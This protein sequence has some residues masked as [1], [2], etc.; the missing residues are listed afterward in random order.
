MNYY[1]KYYSDF[2]DRD[3]NIM[4]I[5][6]YTSS[7]Y[8][9]EEVMVSTE[10]M[11][12]DYTAESLFDSLKPSKASVNILVRELSTILFTGTLNGTC[13]KLF[14]NSSLFWM[15]YVQP[16]VYTQ[17]YKDYYDVLTLQCIDTIA[18][19]QNVTYKYSPNSDEGTIS[20]FFDVITHC[21][22]Y[23]DPNHFIST[24]YVDNSIKAGSLFSVLDNVYIQERNF[25]DESN[26]A[27]NC[28]E[29][30]GSILKYLGLTMIQYRD[31]YYIIEQGS[32]LFQA[33]YSLNKY[34]YS[35]GWSKTGT[36][37]LALTSLSS[38]QIGIGHG[39]GEVGLDG[40]FNKVTVIANNNPL[41]QILPDFDDTND[42]VNMNSNPNMKYEENYSYNDT[43]YNLISGFFK[44]K[45]N[46]N[47]T[48][49]QVLESGTYYGSYATPVSEVTGS[50]RD[51]IVGGC[52]WQ[53]TDSYDINEGV[54]SSL[55]W[56]TWLTMTYSPLIMGLSLPNIQLNK[57]K[58]M[59]LDGGYLIV[60]LKYKFSTD[61]RAHSVIHSKNAHDEYI[62]D[63]MWTSNVDKIGA[64]SWTRQGTTK[65]RAILNVGG[66]CYTGR[67]QTNNGWELISDV[68]A[69]QQRYNSL[70]GGMGW[71]WSGNTRHWYR[72]LNSYGDWE[73][74]TESQ[75]NAFSGTKEDGDCE[76]ANAQ[77]MVRSDNNERVYITPEFYEE[78]TN[79]YGFYLCH[80]NKTNEK[81]Y[82]TEYSLTN[83][84]SYNMN[85]T[86]S[87]DG[88][89][90]KCPDFALY[91]QLEFQVFAP[92]TLGSNPNPR[93]DIAGTT[94]KAVHFS[95]LTIK[96]SKSRAYKSIYDNS[97]VDP[98]TKYTNVIY[99]GF[100]KELDDVE[101]K[102]NTKN[103]YATSYSYAIGKDGNNYY[104]I[105]DFNFGNGI[106]KPEEYLVNKYVNHYQTPKYQYGNVLKNRNATSGR[107]NG[108]LTPFFPLRET[109]GGV[110]R[111]M[112]VRDI[113]YD[114]SANTAKIIAQEI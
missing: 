69:R 89:A 28:G 74:V 87:S 47:Y 97:T 56:K 17:P 45:S 27:E 54:P 78:Y 84:V 36:E 93:T 64:G 22:S 66:Y 46:W 13:V 21:L 109:L 91:G 4:R 96:Y 72:I 49:P 6:I 12:I 30:I 33:S 80:Q 63:L 111:N 90:I 35:N 73:Y 104:Y 94:L 100:A 25:F 19:L 32:N 1:L 70:Y 11:T 39:E 113:S 95:D 79:A 110:Q 43:T 53:K 61:I 50:N 9:P 8:N 62:D 51:N 58:T 108:E 15:G 5:E 82:D 10:S 42:I 57:T 102:V 114:I 67:F 85:I 3:N 44:S 99:E 86:D 112:V 81:I 88:A 14:K 55:N 92:S 38:T 34:V 16:N 37:A 52:F 31:C 2:K 48:E 83:T 71:D 76:Y 103:D 29:V 77:Y 65:F 18:Q 24:I 23:V 106:Q 107:I 101:L 68:T 26:E 60:N 40:V 75:Y 105:T 59:I 41:G 98:D 20:S 7:E